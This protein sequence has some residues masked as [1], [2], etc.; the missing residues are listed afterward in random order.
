MDAVVI[1]DVVIIQRVSHS[2][3]CV[4][5]HPRWHLSAKSPDGAFRLAPAIFD[6]AERVNDFKTPGC[7]NLVSKD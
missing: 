3:I 2:A 4:C 1:I 5:S 7:M 6:Q